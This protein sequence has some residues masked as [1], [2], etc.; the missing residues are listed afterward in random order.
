MTNEN[1]SKLLNAQINAELYS[2]YLYWD[3]AKH[4]D[5]KGMK[6]FANWYKVQAEEEIDHA[7]KFYNYMQD[8]GCYIALTTIAGPK[9]ETEDHMEIAKLGLKHEKE[10]TKMINN[11]YAE[12]FKNNDYRTMQFL[13]WFIAEQAEEETN[14]RDIIGLL[15]LAGES[16]SALF[17]ADIQ[18]GKRHRA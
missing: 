3:F 14:A 11:I 2:A 10:I 12:A 9:V 8:Q 17:M 5:C 7:R 18:M 13:D 15:K 16:R 1:V 6:G 4:F